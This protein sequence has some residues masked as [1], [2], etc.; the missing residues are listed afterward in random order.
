MKKFLLAFTFVCLSIAVHAQK[1][2][3]IYLQ[4]EKQAPFFVKMGDKVHSSAAS[5]YLILSSLKDS[6]YVFTI[7][8]PGTQSGETKFSVTINNNDKG[9]LIKNFDDGPGLF[10]LQT[11]S[12]SKPVA[13]GLKTGGQQTVIRTDAFTKLLSQATDDASLLIQ[14]LP[15]VIAI[16]EPERPKEEKKEVVAEVKPET[17]TEAKLDKAQEIKTDKP[18]EL[19]TEKPIELKNESSADS[20]TLVTKNN[21]SAEQQSSKLDTVLDS[22][23]ATEAIAVKEPQVETKQDDQEIVEKEVLSTPYQRSVVTRRSESSTTEGFGLVFID[24]R[25]GEKDTIRLVIPNP[26]KAFNDADEIVQQ[27]PAES[28][29]EE[30]KE[31]VF[32]TQAT[33]QPGKQKNSCNNIASDKDFLKLRKN[34]AAESN[35]EQ[36]IAEGKKY[37]R[38]KCFTTEQV[39]N[40]SGLFLTSASKYQFFDAAFAHVSDSEEF[41]TLGLEI[42]DEYYSKRFKAL[43]GE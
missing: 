6:V 11:L 34:M 7:G 30:K 31:P 22:V 27:V 39:R 25:T 26:K 15:P 19:K 13:S 29:V 43:I 28:H 9:F 32:S 41:P 37:F 16:A 4:S 17:I 35:D 1:V 36:M 3:F 20:E 14:T 23:K 38:N 21:E 33:T 10:D 5:G 18:V 24:D 42:K 8:Y 12:V 40:L 2:F